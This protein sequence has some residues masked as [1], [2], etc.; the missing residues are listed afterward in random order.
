MPNSNLPDIQLTKPE[1]EIDINKVGITNLLLPIFIIQKNGGHQNS[2]ASINCCVS[3]DSNLKGIS[4]SRIP[5]TIHT[6]LDLPLGNVII[7]KIVDDVMTNT[8]CSDVHLSYKF[9]YFIKKYAPETKEP[10]FVHHTATFEGIKTK[11]NYRFKVGIEVVATN[12][13]PCSKSISKYGAH[14][15]RVNIRLKAEQK[16]GSFLWLEDLIDIAESSASCEI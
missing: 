16:L 13:C 15:Q 4:M 3:L 6:Y 7:K 2:T 11:T 1:Y 9:P 14:N 12:L 10:G 5:R 8:E